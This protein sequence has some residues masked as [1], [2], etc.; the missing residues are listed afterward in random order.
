MDEGD[1]YISSQLVTGGL[2][3]LVLSLPL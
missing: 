2:K 1:I 3:A